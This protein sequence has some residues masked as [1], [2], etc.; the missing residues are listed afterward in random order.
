[1]DLVPPEFVSPDDQAEDLAVETNR[2]RQ[3]AVLDIEQVLDSEAPPPAE[4]AE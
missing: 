1:L 4:D 2:D 3:E